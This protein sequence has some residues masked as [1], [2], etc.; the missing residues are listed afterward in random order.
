MLAKELGNLLN[1]APL[2]AKRAVKPRFSTR[3][4][5]VKVDN[6]DFAFKNFEL[7]QFYHPDS[8]MPP[9]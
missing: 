4:S 9:P 8:T 1:A 5:T 6:S 7:A 3:L 2:Q